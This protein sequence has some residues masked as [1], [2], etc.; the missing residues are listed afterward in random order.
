MCIRD[1]FYGGEYGISTGRTSPGWPV[2]MI[3]LYFENQRNAAV[4]SRNTGMCIVSMHVKNVPVAI[5][6][7]HGISDRLFME[8]CLWEN[9][10]TGIKLGIENEAGNQINLMNIF[11]K[12]VDIP[13]YFTPSDKNIPGKGDKYLINNFVYGLVM[14]LS[15]IHISEPTRP[16]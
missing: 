3:D 5:E 6:L 4:L 10:E 1:R 15:L 7:Q 8:E 16:Y 11:C 2:M 13:I 9:V 12:N 14:D